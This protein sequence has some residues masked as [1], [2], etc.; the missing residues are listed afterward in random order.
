MIPIAIG[1]VLPR[2]N[3]A[4]GQGIK[5][6]G[7]RKFCA[8]EIRFFAKRQTVSRNAKRHTLTSLNRKKHETK[9]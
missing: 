1:I 4:V 6:C 3:D 7:G 2:L 8:S 5:F 9:F